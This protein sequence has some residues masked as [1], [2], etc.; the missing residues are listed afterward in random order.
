MKFSKTCTLQLPFL[1]KQ[2][3]AILYLKEGS[4]PTKRKI[5]NLGS[6]RFVKEK[7]ERNFPDKV[8]GT[9]QAGWLEIN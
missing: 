3:D 1:G 9:E 8:K 2:Q 4:N 7:E 5:R 6:R